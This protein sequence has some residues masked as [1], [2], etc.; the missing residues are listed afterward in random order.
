M[1]SNEVDDDVLVDF[2]QLCTEMFLQDDLKPFHRK[3]KGFP[4]C[5]N[6]R[7]FVFVLLPCSGVLC[8]FSCVMSSVTGSYTRNELGKRPVSLLQ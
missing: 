1:R 6:L 3:E 8:L 5:K 7:Y 4:Q 2:L